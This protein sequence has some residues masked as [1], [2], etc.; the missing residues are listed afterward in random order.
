MYILLLTGLR[1]SD[2]PSLDLRDLDLGQLVVAG[3][4]S[5]GDR[6]HQDFITQI[7]VEWLTEHPEPRH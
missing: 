4:H 3:R 7:D 5:K 1:A 2:T 6:S